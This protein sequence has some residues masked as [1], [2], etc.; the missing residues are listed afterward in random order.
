MIEKVRRIKQNQIDKKPYF[1]KIDVPHFNRYYTGLTKSE[2][3][4]LTAATGGGK[5][6]FCKFLFVIKAIESAI[7][8]NIDYKCIY[9]ALEETKEQFMASIYSYF[10]FTKLGLSYNIKD[11]EGMTVDEN[12]K[13]VDI[14]DTMIDAIEKVAPTVEQYMSYVELITQSLSPVNI[15]KRVRD[16]ADKEIKFYKI[17]EEGKK[18]RM[19]IRQAETEKYTEKVIDEDKF[20]TVVVDHVGNIAS[21]DKFNSIAELAHYGRA[22]MASLYEYNVVYV[23]QQVKDKGSIEN[24]KANMVYASIDGL[25]NYKAL[26]DDAHTIIGITN[27]N[28]YGLTRIGSSNQIKVESYGDNLRVV[29]I[30]KNRYGSV[31]KQMVFGFLGKVNFIEPFPIDDSTFDI[32]TSKFLI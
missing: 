12:N 26:S 4:I 6:S 3:L 1:I 18:E 5:T 15:L 17:N 31:N 13:V 21:K 22:Y 32:T 23:Q 2:I 14:S 10:I 24:K 30:L 20:R 25:A 7:K 11:F 8:Y 16:F 9:F 19:S 27:P 28:T 29:E